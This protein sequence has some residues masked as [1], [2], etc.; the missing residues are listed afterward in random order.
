[1]PSLQGMGFKDVVY[2]L[3]NM[4]V[5]IMA[6]GRGKVSAQSITAGT[7]VRKNEVVYV[8]LN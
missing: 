3:E 4:G 7:V 6:R 8:Q 2:V 5:K 1:M